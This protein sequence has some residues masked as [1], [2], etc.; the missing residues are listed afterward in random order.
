MSWSKVTPVLLPCDP[1]SLCRRPYPGHPKGCPN[2]G[3]RPTCP[4]Q[5]ERWTL[6]TIARYDW[7][8]IWVVF[9]F[10]EHVERMRVAHPDWSQRQCE[11]CLYWQGTARRRLRE[12]VVEFLGE[13]AIPGVADEVYYVP[14]AHG[15]DVTAT[16]ATLGVALEWPPQVVTRHVA[17]VR[18]G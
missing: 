2:F 14:E 8:A 10:G 17:I 13:A 1:G 15:C 11:C 6:E 9:E 18:I 12:F 7:Y 5:A 4:P 16:M 3:K